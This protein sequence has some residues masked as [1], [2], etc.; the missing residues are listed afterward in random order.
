MTL[1]SKI[2]FS[3]QVRRKIRGAQPLP[4]HSRREAGPF[5]AVTFESSQ[6]GDS[7]VFRNVSYG[8]IEC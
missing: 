3:S 2:D 5:E 8:F 1:P 4:D 6:I 7:T